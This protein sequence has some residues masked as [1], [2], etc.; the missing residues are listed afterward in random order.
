MSASLPTFLIVAAALF[1]VV[2]ERIAPG[3]DLPPSKGWYYRAI[4]INFAQIAITLATNAIWLKLAGASSAVH[5]AALREPALEGFFAW[6]VGSLIFYW[7][8]RLR[9][10]DGFWLI[11]HQIHHSPARIE[12]LTSFYKHPVEILSDSLLAAF[13]LYPLLGA[14]LEGALWFN[15]FAAIG[16]F[17]YHANIRAPSWMRYLI[18][19]P[20]LHAIHHARDVHR[21]NFSDLP[22]WDRLFGTYHDAVDF[23]PVCGFPGDGEQRLGA[24]LMFRDVYDAKAPADPEAAGT[25]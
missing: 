18:Q 21:H 15:A 24:M 6:I 16:E 20:Q 23:A 9:H 22:I 5:L 12:T 2:L 7:W 14:S 10:A 19:T 13:M 8:H 3:R 17:F 25:P 11:F 4:A 1:F